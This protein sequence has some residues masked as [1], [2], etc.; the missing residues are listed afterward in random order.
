M[1]LFKNKKNKI[2]N[3]QLLAMHSTD[4]LVHISIVHQNILSQ[5]NL[6]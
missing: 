5:V 1:I 2:I 3:L 6:T 4:T